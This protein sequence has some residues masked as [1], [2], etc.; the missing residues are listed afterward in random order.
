MKI[1]DPKK[2]REAKEL[3]SA[4]MITGQRQGSKIQEA[5]KYAHLPVGMKWV[6]S[7]LELAGASWITYIIHPVGTTDYGVAAV[8]RK[9]FYVKAIRFGWLSESADAKHIMER[10]ETAIHAF[11][12]EIEAGTA[13]VVKDGDLLPD[14]SCAFG[15]SQEA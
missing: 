3:R 9:G 10:V 4:K 5:L 2:Q 1:P 7:S 6:N 15:S 14:D 11:Q 12:R 13:Q 8:R